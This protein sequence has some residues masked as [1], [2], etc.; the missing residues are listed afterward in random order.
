MPGSSSGGGGG[1]RRRRNLVP[2][3]RNGLNALKMEAAQ[4]L[5]VQVPADGYYGFVTARE[6]GALGGYMVKNMIAS[7]EQQL[8]T[9]AGGMAGGQMGGSR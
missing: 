1:S 6:T 4:S 7:A 2:E 3:A 8:S 5:G 9:G